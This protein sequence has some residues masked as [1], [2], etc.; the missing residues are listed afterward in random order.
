ML[1]KPMPPAYLTG[2]VTTFVAICLYGMAVLGAVQALSDLH[3]TTK[4]WVAIAIGLAGLAALA[5]FVLGHV[6]NTGARTLILTLDR[7]GLTVRNGPITLSGRPWRVRRP[8]RF[9]SSLGQIDL[10]NARMVAMLMVRIRF[11][12]ERTVL[13]GVP[14]A[15]CLWLADVL[16]SALA[17]EIPFE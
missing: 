14:K 16:N 2:I 6:R 10:L 3:R 12:F 15:D 9:R 5:T 8:R 4:D 13:T 11:G 1:T 7:Q 17:R